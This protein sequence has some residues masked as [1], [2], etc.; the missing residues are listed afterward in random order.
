MSQLQAR[1]HGSFR[2]LMPIRRRIEGSNGP[3][4]VNFPYRSPDTEQRTGSGKPP[5]R[6]KHGAS[7][8]FGATG[9][10][11]SSVSF[12]GVLTNG[13]DEPRPFAPDSM[14]ASRAISTSSSSTLKFRPCIKISPHGPEE[15][16]SL[17]KKALMRC[18]LFTRCNIG[19]THE[20]VPASLFKVIHR[21]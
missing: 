17:K 10:K 8:R 16:R 2:P 1:T 14:I 20:S 4:Y 13:H 6:Q 11:P 21:K 18:C 9:T 15:M 7:G 19:I 3:R 5:R 12:T